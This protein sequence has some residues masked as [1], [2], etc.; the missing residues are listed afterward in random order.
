MNNG[1]DR[2]NRKNLKQ[3]LRP[4]VESCYLKEVGGKSIV[5]QVLSPQVTQ[6]DGRWNAEKGDVIAELLDMMEIE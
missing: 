1:W 3:G 4:V 5:V 6:S 2:K